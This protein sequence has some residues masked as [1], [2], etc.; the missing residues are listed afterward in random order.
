MSV[1]LLKNLAGG[2]RAYLVPVGFVYGDEKACP[3]AGTGMMIPGFRIIARE[4]SDKLCDIRLSYGE[5]K[6]ALSD[7]PHEIAGSLSTQLR[8]LQK[9]REP[10]QLKNSDPTLAYTRPRIMGVLNVT[11]DSF[12]DGGKFIDPDAAVRHARQLIA[13]GADIIDIGG[14]STRPGANP[15]WEGEEAER[16]VPVIEALQADGVLLSIDTRHSFVMEKATQAGAH[17][18]NDV[19]ALSYDG[20][21]LRIAAKSGAPIILMHSQG[22]P[23]TMQDNPSY[24]DTLLDVYDY[25]EERVRICEE[26]GIDRSRLILDPGI[27]FGKRMV[28]D[29][30]A[31]INGLPFLHALGLPILFGAS[32]KSFIG[33]ISGEEDAS[34]RMPGSLAAAMKAVEMGAQIV[35]VHD[36]AETKQALAMVQAFKDAAILDAMH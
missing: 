32:R 14:E 30:L 36:V 19:T 20:E 22:D 25:L 2:A 11:P 27:G 21:S 18:I 28:Q 8:N 15:V 33:A 7:L 34:K 4:G 10:L 35:R 12:S 23:K 13:E 5:V 9:P 26:A 3:F 17:I 6:N 31:L 16:V 1:E 24:S 29:N